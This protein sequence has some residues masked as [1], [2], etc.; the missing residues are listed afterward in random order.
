MSDNQKF[1]TMIKKEK[2]KKWL[3][4]IGLSSAV[5]VLVG[6][7]LVLGTYVV[8]NQMMAKQAQREVT[9]F[10]ISDL[11]F[12]PN[13]VSTSQY[14]TL[15]ATTRA[16]LVSEREK[17]VDGYPVA[18][19][20]KTVTF[21]LHGQESAIEASPNMRQK[22]HSNQYIAT[23]HQ[24]QQKEPLFFNVAYPKW[25]NQQKTHA[26]RVPPIEPTHEAASLSQMPNTLGEVA[27]TFDKRYNYTEILNMLP[28]NVM[29]NYYW[30]G[31]HSSRLDSTSTAGR[32]IGLN[33]NVDGN[34]ELVD[35]EN[36]PLDAN[37]YVGYQGLKKALSVASNLSMLD[38]DIS[39]IKDAKKQLA[40][41]LKNSEFAG[42]IVTGRTENL[43]KLDQ[44]PYVYATN[45]GVTTPIMPYL[46]PLK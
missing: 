5:T 24:T 42:V 4:I 15:T 19:P 9:Q 46:E 12:S 37:Q 27:I 18:Y 3:K 11:I 10:N 25:Y 7:G 8:R 38:N 14:Y 1:E 26:K 17:N 45:V 28:K 35:K 6:G 2:R 31:N 41:N 39:L 36:G 13:I 16:T 30:L 32:Y 40:A 21:N 34:G 22:P 29:I 43:A 33:A 20:E 23:N 44:M